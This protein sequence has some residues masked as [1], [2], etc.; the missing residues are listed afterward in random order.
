MTSF[1]SA[2]EPQNILNSFTPKSNKDGG[3]HL[4]YENRSELYKAIEMKNWDAV[5]RRSRSNPEEAQFWHEDDEC[6]NHLPLHY[7]I[8]LDAPK[9]VIVAIVSAYSL[10]L[11]KQD[12]KGRLPIHLIMLKNELEEDLIE[13]FLSLFPDGCTVKDSEGRVALSLYNKNTTQLYRYIE[14]KQWDN[15]TQ[16]VKYHPE[17]ASTWVF[18][19]E[20][21]G[22]LRWRLTPLH[23]AI[24]YAAP[25]K[26]IDALL[27]VSPDLAK[28]KDDEGMLPVH[29]AFRNN[30]SDTIIDI[31]LKA[32]P[33][34]V[35]IKDKFDQVPLAHSRSIT[36]ERKGVVEAYASAMVQLERE[37]QEKRRDE[38]IDKKIQETKLENQEKRDQEKEIEAATIH[39]KNEVIVRIKKESDEII[40]RLKKESSEQIAN[41][42]EQ[43][44]QLKEKLQ[45]YE[46]ELKKVEHILYRRK[47]VVDEV[48]K[49]RDKNEDDEEIYLGEVL[50]DNTQQIDDVSRL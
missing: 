34:G 35:R 7:A 9:D 36:S 5:I 43:I 40:A 2:L 24:I 4:S 44:K 27:Y 15:V 50:V 38:I 11:Q 12:S 28:K 13:T 32:Y 23:A 20:K 26:V 37:N 46:K 16:H 14:A 47:N 19:K 31:L 45:K 10:A 41:R 21:S 8:T 33:E 39:R 25:V 1:L 49:S 29:L 22:K 48:M 6:N 42:D 18:R 3:K 17:E 30:T